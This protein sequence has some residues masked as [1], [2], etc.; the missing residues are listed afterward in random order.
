MKQMTPHISQLPNEE[1]KNEFMHELLEKY[2][3]VNKLLIDGSC[4]LI[5]KLAKM[6]AS[7]K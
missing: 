3:A 5:F 6:V 4:K 7:K 1:K 2:L